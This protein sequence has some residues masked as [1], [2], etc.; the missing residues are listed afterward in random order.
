MGCGGQ[1]LVGAGGVGLQQVEQAEVNGIQR[2]G[3][4]I[5]LNDAI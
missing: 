1:F 4:I 3:E 2:H 5:S